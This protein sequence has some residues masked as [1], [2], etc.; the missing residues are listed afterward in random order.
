MKVS[1]VII[2]LN[3]GSQL[4]VCLKSIATLSTDIVV[5]VDSRTA[6]N[7]AKIASDLGCRV[8]TREFDNFSGQKNYAD[9]LAKNDWILSLDSD[10]SA[11]PGLI[12]AIIN[13]PEKP[14][15]QAYS[16]PRQN[17]IFGKYIKHTNWDP[18]GLV[19]L[20]NRQKCTWFGEIHEEINFPGSVGRLYDSIIHDNY[21]TVESFMARQDSYSSQRALELYR[22]GVKFSLARFIFDPLVD[23]GRRYVWHA[24]FLDGLHGLFL[25][26]LMVLYHLS[27]WIKLWQKYQKVSS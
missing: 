10:E 13:L 8:Y 9:S 24:G 27:V 17:I 26:Y 21:H 18:D 4:P 23:F 19:R 11:T 7:T 16:I 5:V 25:S 2:A 14:L 1:V 6:D 12:S 15:F 3:A 22:R 20:F